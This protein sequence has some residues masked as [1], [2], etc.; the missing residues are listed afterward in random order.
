MSQRFRSSMAAVL[1]LMMLVALVPAAAFAVEPLALY[2]PE[3]IYEPDDSVK[4]AVEY[5]PASEVTTHTIGD[6]EDQDWTRF[7]VDA[8]GQPFLIETEPTAGRDIDLEM[9]VFGIDQYGNE[10][11]LVNV[12]DV[13]H[14]DDAL[15]NTYGSQCFFSAPAPGEYAVRVQ[16]LDSS[17]NGE[18]GAYTLTMSDGIA[19]RIAGDTRFDTAAK[20]SRTIWPMTNLWGS[21]QGPDTPYDPTCI[22]VSNGLNWPDAL[23]GSAFATAADGVLLLATP[24]ELPDV[25]AAEMQRLLTNAYGYDPADAAYQGMTVY[26][27]GGEAAVGQAVEDEIAGMDGVGEIVRLA[28]NTRYETAVNIG[29][30]FVDVAG[31]GVTHT[32]F[33]VGSANP[34]DALA[35]GPVAAA[36]EAP[37]LLSGKSDVPTATID[38]LTDNAI[39]RVVVV[40]G[41]AAVDASAY[42]EIEANVTSIERVAGATR[43]QTAMNVA[44]WGVD[45]ASMD[46]GTVVLVSGE[47]FA[48]GLAAGPI[49][50]YSNGPMLLTRPD[51]LVDEVYTFF[52]DNVLPSSA[53]YVVGGP[54]A[55]DEDVFWEFKAGIWP[56]LTSLPD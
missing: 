33:V 19:R 1:V 10:V 4:T 26:I 5:D 39:E 23:A 42:A 55:V 34:W 46:A 8:T 16:A 51:Y 9:E 41:E 22:I 24:D 44:Q 43:Y 2:Y 3:D 21:Y 31:L 45:N 52:E 30:E 18:I 28:G 35:A 11:E 14:S 50:H 13:N 6:A 27:L 38:F 54:V 15:W 29:T 12:E 17:G 48:D 20:V 56:Y 7:S 37:V 32:A 47:S 25:T 40:G 49:T 36:A 53:S